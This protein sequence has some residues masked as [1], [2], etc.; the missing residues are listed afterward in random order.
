M[1]GDERDAI[2]RSG[3]AH[4]IHVGQLSHDEMARSFVLAAAK[5]IRFRETHNPPFI[6]KL[7]RPEKRT[8]YHTVAGAIKLVLTLEEWKRAGGRS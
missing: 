2:M 8:E 4:V 7:Y 6:A 5:I 1:L 3:V